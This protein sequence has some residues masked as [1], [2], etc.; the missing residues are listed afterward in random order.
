MRYLVQFLYAYCHF[1]PCFVDF[2]S[3]MLRS[4][5]DF[6]EMDI[7]FLISCYLVAV[8]S[9]CEVD[10]HFTSRTLLLHKLVKIAI[11]KVGA[12]VRLVL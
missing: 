8:S 2:H 12:F 9:G 7:V 5:S 11:L 4:L 1:L 6:V 3:V 10:A